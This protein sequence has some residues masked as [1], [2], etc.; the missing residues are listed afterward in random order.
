MLWALTSHEMVAANLSMAAGKKIKLSW[1]A[2][3]GPMVF[4][5]GGLADK[6][7]KV[8]LIHCELVPGIMHGHNLG[9][10][11]A[12]TQHETDCLF[13]RAHPGSNPWLSR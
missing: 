3:S 7:P 5:P 12:N 11:I 1:C 2:R 4:R 10:V 13:D 9:N 6:G 8:R